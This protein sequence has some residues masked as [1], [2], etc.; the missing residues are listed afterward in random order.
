MLSQENKFDIF[1]LSETWLNSSV[2]D[3]EVGL[4]D[5]TMV[6]NDR[7]NKRG[8]GTAILVKDGIPY[9]HRTDLTDDSA[10]TC[11]VEVNRSKCKTLF[12]CCVYRS[13]DY[14][15]DQLIDHLNDSLSQL[16]IESEIVVLGDLNV[17]FLLKRENFGYNLKQKLKILAN[18]NDLEQLINSPTRITDQSRTAIDLVLVNNSHQ[19]VE[20]GVIPS[21]ISDHC[22]VYC[23][24]K[25]DVHKARP[26]T[27]EYRS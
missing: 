14:N 23:T 16:P 22:I 15:C 10:E 12:V 18:S 21:A 25:S 6:R 26:K 5:Y 11:W 24:I 7:S 3:S 19:I 2:P 20:S 8:G 4:H 9:R 27:I 13:P 1:T 17:D